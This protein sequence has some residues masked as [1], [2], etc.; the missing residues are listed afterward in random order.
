MTNSESE[1]GTSREDLIQR[2]AMMEMMIA[3]GR[4]STTRC[5]WIF[6]LW[7]LVNIAGMAWEWE[8]PSYWIWPT[9]LAVGFGLLF[10]IRAMQKRDPARCANIEGRAVGAIWSMMGLATTLYVA[11]GISRHLTWQYSYVAAIF[12]FVGLAHAI[13]AMILRWRVQ[14]VVAALWWVGG[15]A[16][17]FAHSGNEIFVVFPLEMFFGMV[18]FGLY[19]MMLDRRDRNGQV[20]AN[21]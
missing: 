21:A 5:G 9:V 18:L 4:R 6:V 12:M 19:G 15:I 13:S 3:E 20:S 8:R 16:M 11:A 14:G 17:F 7:G 2:L 1:D 10:L